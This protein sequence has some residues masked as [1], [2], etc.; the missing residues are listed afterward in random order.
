MYTF[1]TKQ[2]KKMVLKVHDQGVSFFYFDNRHM[3]DTFHVGQSWSSV[4]ALVSKLRHQQKYSAN[5]HSLSAWQQGEEL[6]IKLSR[7]DRRCEETLTFSSEMTVK[8][9]SA[10]DKLPNLN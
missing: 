3:D 4:H 5:D 9:L 7:S 8:I 6:T 10:F 2:S 1:S